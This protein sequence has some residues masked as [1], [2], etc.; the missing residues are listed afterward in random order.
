MI[1]SIRLMDARDEGREEE[2]KN[3]E[4]AIKR[5]EDAEQRAEDA[6]Q[7]AEDAEQRA[8]DAEAIIAIYK[9]KYGE[10]A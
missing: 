8:E 1:E 5:A 7:R 4:V 3:T 9:A 6:E 10:L 2:R